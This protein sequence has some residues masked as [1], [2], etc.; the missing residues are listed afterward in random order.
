MGEGKRLTGGNGVTEKI[1]RHAHSAL[2]TVCEENPTK[3]VF[4]V[5]SSY[6]G[7]VASHLLAGKAERKP[8]DDLSRY[9]VPDDLPPFSAPNFRG[10]ISFGYPLCLDKNQAR[11]TILQD[12]ENSRIFFVAGSKDPMIKGLADVAAKMQATNSNHVLYQMI[13]SGGHNPLKVTASK[14][15]KANDDGDDETSSEDDSITNLQT[16]LTTFLNE[17]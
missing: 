13:P 9:F 1:L 5:T 10:V 14:K 8:K 12:L 2:L 11:E 3:R 6:G 15:R 16:K 7:R 17:S 4:V